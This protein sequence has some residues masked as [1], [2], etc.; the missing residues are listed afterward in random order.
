MEKPHIG[1]TFGKKSSS[2][3]S[4]YA[5]SSIYDKGGAQ[6]Q[7]MNDDLCIVQYGKGGKD[8]IDQPAMA[9]T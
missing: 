2:Q 3:L 8:S 1:E 5:A 4:H 7:P 9:N 6:G